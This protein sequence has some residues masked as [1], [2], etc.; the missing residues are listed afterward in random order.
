[1]ATSVEALIESERGI[2]SQVASFGNLSQMIATCR[3]SCL[4]EAER[5]AE[6]TKTRLAKLQQDLA[7]R[8]SKL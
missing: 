5:A 7:R 4:E 8:S 1:M 6:A 2:K 3:F